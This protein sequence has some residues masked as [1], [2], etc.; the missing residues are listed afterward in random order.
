M[1]TITIHVNGDAEVLVNGQPLAAAVAAAVASAPDAPVPDVA[2]ESLRHDTPREVA[3]AATCH[4]ANRQYCR[5][6]G[7]FTQKPWSEAPGW[8]KASAIAGVRAIESGAV[9]RPEQSHESWSKQKVDDGWVY[10]PQKSEVEKTHPCLVP[11]DKLPPE[12]R[13]KDSIFFTLASALLGKRL[14]LSE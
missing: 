8:Q 7:D 13:L 14:V 1:R 6:L 9:T 10:G 12:Q 5:M 3:I 2:D 11:F 4:E